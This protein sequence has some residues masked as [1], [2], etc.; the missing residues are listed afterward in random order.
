MEVALELGAIRLGVIGD[1]NLV[2]SQANGDFKVKEEKMK[3]YH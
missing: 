2:V 3:V 1:S